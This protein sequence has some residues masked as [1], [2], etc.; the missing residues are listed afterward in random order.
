MAV[1]TPCIPLGNRVHE[2]SNVQNGTMLFNL[3]DCRED[4]GGRVEYFIFL[5][6]VLYIDIEEKSPYQCIFVQCGQTFKEP[7][8]MIRHLLTCRVFGE[9]GTY[10]CYKCKSRHILKKSTGT[11]R[12][13]DHSKP[14]NEEDASATSSAIIVP[15]DTTSNGSHQDEKLQAPRTCS[16][17]KGRASQI[18]D[19][20]WNKRKDQI[21]ELYITQNYPLGEVMRLM[22]EKERFEATYVN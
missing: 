2:S 16:P 13:K 9:G 21:R 6:V 22:N 15:F 14:G 10:R 20:E 4:E 11:E 5:H 17:M 1:P 19:E 18:K 8:L 12:T 3:H 7:L